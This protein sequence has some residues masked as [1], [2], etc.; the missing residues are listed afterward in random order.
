MTLKGIC[1]RPAEDF[2]RAG[3]T[4]P[5][6]LNME[7]FVPESENQIIAQGR[8]VEFIIAPSHNRTIGLEIFKNLNN[9]KVVQLTGAGYDKVDL[10]AANRYGVPVAHAPDQNSKTVAQYVFIMLGVLSRR[11]LEGHNQVKEG[12]FVEAR[13]KLITPTLHEFGGQNLAII[14]MGRIGRE[15]AKIGKFFDFQLGYFDIQKLM[16]KIENR[17]SVKY[18]DWEKILKWADIISLHLPRNSATKSFIGAKELRLMR[19]NAILINIARG[20]I[21]DE[22]ALC[23]ALTEGQIRAAGVDVFDQEPPPREHLYFNINPEVRD[24]LLLSPHMGGRT[25]E[26]NRRMFSFA[27]ENVRAFLVDGKPLKGVINLDD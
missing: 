5:D 26:A 25:L 10:A 17:F 4:I 2:E 16:P 20:G 7:F 21:V 24:R 22:N 13:K 6:S 23:R 9:L 27:V 8:S 18:F 19:P 1:L 15:V 12:N 14:G 3:I 11:M